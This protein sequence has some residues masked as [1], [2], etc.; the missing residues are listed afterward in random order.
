MSSSYPRLNREWAPASEAAVVAGAGRGPERTVGVDGR[1]VGVRPARER[2]AVAEQLPAGALA[3]AG[4]RGRAAVALAGL[5]LLGGHRDRHAVVGRVLVLVLGQIGLGVE[6]LVGDGAA[7]ASDDAV[8]VD[9]VVVA[10]RGGDDRGEEEGR[11]QEAQGAHGF[12]SS[13]TTLHNSGAFLP[14]QPIFVGRTVA[15]DGIPNFC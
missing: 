7:V 2:E 11:E 8:V 12:F 4:A 10:T 9:D 3:R 15:R 1:G 6:L 14:S 13:L 5:G